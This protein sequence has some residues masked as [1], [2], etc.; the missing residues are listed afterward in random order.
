VKAAASIVVL[1]LLAAGCGGSPRNT[2]AQGSSALAFAGCMRAHGVSTYPDPTGNGQLAKDSPEQLGVTGSQFASADNAC[3]HLLPNGVGARSATQQEAV[4]A[5]GLQFSQC[6][7]A[8]GLPDFPDPAGDGRVPDPASVG[9]DQGSPK[10][11][12]ANQACGRYRPPYI[13]SNAAYDAYARTHA[14][15]S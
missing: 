15:G 8:H 2:A 10:F 3:R 7:R 9:I 6:V 1:G 4:K 14:N 5:L 13:P 12:A 11:K